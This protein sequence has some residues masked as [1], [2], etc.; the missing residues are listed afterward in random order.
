MSKNAGELPFARQLKFFGFLGL[1]ASIMVGTGEYL[2][3]F[4]PDGFPHDV[5]YSYFL[6]L[7]PE[8]FT[9]GQFLMV[10]FIP[11]YIF[12][13][14]HLYL[15]LRP[16]SEKLAKAVLILGIYAFV[17]GGIWV[18]SRAHLGA[19]IQAL[20]AANVPDLKAQIIASY[21]LRVES[22]VQI[23]R[24]IVLAISVCFVWAILRGGTLYPKWVA[25]FNPI[26]LLI[27]V[28]VLFFYVHPIGRCL[29]PTAMNV[30]HFGLFSASLFA[31]KNYPSK[32]QSS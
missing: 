3:H 9:L 19:T 26:L 30:A 20:E 18:G 13:Y 4:N 8:R 11:L 25:L 16:G 1:L 27:I 17:I 10:P 6:G 23:L 14:W 31:L 5:P 28:F 32:T 15:A 7:P 24:I 29:A 2:I 21:E 22:L 12:G